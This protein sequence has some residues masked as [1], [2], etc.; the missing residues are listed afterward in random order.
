MKYNPLFTSQNTQSYNDTI[1]LLLRLTLGAVILPHGAQ[2]LLG[3]FG[4]GGFAG[5][6][7]YLTNFRGLP[8]ILGLLVIIIQF[9]GSIMLLV[10]FFTRINTIAMIAILTGMIFKGHTEHGFFMNWSGNQAGEGFEYHILAIGI[11]VA[12]LFTG[13]G[14]YSVDYKLFLTEKE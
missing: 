7:E 4:G 14:R 11:A 9:F 10:G 2:M 3:W 1:A 12:L 13:S 8:Y 6:M 5:S